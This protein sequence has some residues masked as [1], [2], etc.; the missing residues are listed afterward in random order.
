MKKP[1]EMIGGIE[2][3]HDCWTLRAVAQRYSTLTDGKET[4]FFLQLELYG[5][6]S[7]GSS[8]ISELERNIRGY[9]HRETIP[10]TPGLYDYYE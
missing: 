8:P 10:S 4:N 7:V 5:L 6:G 3:L 9:Q 1:I 2:Y